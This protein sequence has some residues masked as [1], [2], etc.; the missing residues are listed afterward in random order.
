MWR[1]T[2]SQT[3]FNECVSECRTLKKINYYNENEKKV[4]IFTRIDLPHPDGQT[5]IDMVDLSISSIIS[6]RDAF[7]WQSTAKLNWFVTFQWGAI[8]AFID[9]SPTLLENN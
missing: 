8:V 5:R 6:S 7:N 4:E 9:H 3:S 2:L 1:R